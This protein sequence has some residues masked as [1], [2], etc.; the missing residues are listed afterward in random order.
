[1]ALL[2]ITSCQSVNEIESSA[3]AVTPAPQAATEP[4][5]NLRDVPSRPQLSYPIEQRRAIVEGLIA[6]RENARYT[7]QV[8]RYQAGLSSQPPPAAPPPVAPDLASSVVADTAPPAAAA[9]QPPPG[10]DSDPYA[11][12]ARSY[13]NGG[14]DDFI[15]ELQRTT[16]PTPA[17][18]PQA[19]LEPAAGQAATPTVAR[20][21]AD[22]PP[23][24]PL[25]TRKPPPI[26]A[27]GLLAETSGWERWFGWIFSPFGLSGEDSVPPAAPV[28]AEP[29]APPEPPLATP[30]PEAE[31]PAPPA[32]ATPAPLPSTG[33][34]AALSAQPAPPTGPQLARSPMPR[35]RPVGPDGAPALP[36]P[37]RFERQAQPSPSAVAALAPLPR[38]KPNPADSIQVVS[39]D[40][41]FRFDELPRPAFRPL[42]RQIAEAPASPRAIPASLPKPAEPPAKKTAPAAPSAPVAAAEPPPAPAAAGD[43]TAAEA[44]AIPETATGRAVGPVLRHSVIPFPP[45]SALMPASIEPALQAI[46]QD[47]AASGAKIEVIGS[48]QDPALAF[49]RARSVALALVNLGADADAVEIAV[50][51]N[52]TADQAHLLLKEGVAP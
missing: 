17:G 11:L 3:A 33:P 25:D 10:T 28:P 5:P 51:R 15:R 42:A 20:L 9:G 43:S 19:A 21:D 4:V 48:G 24:A 31:L 26:L 29:E 2:A 6:D 30:D 52:R 8:V 22:A 16:E 38:L 50:A 44:R 34:P 12:G 46:L 13:D 47:A 37:G 45:D 18:E 23:T 7:D 1:L 49:D 27:A 14:L 32:T 35:L 39:N 40:R 36:E 41:V